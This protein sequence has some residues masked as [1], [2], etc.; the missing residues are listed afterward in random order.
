MTPLIFVRLF[1]PAMRSAAELAS[2]SMFRISV[3]EWSI[4][5]R[6]FAASMWLARRAGAEHDGNQPE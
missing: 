2:W 3:A 6:S 5:A 4:L 1:I